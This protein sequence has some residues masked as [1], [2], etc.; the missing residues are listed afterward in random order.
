[1]R[2]AHFVFAVALGTIATG[3]VGCAGFNRTGGVGGGAVV[4]GETRSAAANSGSTTN[5]VAT[6]GSVTTGEA[7]SY[8]RSSE[9]PH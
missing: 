4:S 2:I 3:A 9:V 5:S 7:I 8:T 6:N 1:M